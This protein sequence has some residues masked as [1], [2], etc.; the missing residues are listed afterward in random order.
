MAPARGAAGGRPDRPGAAGGRARPGPGA[1]VERAA[2][3]RPAVGGGEVHLVRDP[4]APARRPARPR[5]RGLDGARRGRADLRRARAGADRGAGPGA[6][7]GA[8]RA[9][10]PGHGQGRVGLRR[11][12]GRLDPRRAVRP[13]L[14]RRAGLGAARA[15]GSLVPRR[16]AA[17][18]AGGARARLRSRSGGGADPGGGAAHARVPPERRA[19]AGPCHGRGPGRVVGPP[20]P[21]C[22]GLSAGGEGRAGPGR[23]RAPSARRRPAPAPGS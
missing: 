5:A 7:P 8:E 12:R 1:S 16:R 18:P 19:L 9:A 15:A 22:R 4:V 17:D 23:P 13:S 10:R 6:A 11:P 14:V 2:H 21:R 20:R 3:L